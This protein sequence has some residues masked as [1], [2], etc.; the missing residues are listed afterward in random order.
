MRDYEPAAGQ[1]LPPGCMDIPDTS[2]GD[3]CGEC[4]RTLWLSDGSVV[5][6]AE[7]AERFPAPADPEAVVRWAECAAF[8]PTELACRDFEAG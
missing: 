2:P 4:A 8:P 5:C 7:L 3:T 1:N 6:G